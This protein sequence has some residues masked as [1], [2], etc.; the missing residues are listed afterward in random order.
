MA[1]T[2]IETLLSKDYVALKE[3]C[4]KIIATKIM[5]KVNDLKVGLLAKI[6]GISADKQ[7][8]MMTVAPAPKE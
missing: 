7:Q 5:N 6:N 2:M 8:E 3:G 1:E 4:E